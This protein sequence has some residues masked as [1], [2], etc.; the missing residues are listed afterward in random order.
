MG[1]G[2]GLR[3]PPL[4]K[5][6]SPTARCLRPH[7][8]K[9]WISPRIEAPQPFW[10]VWCL[11]T[12]TVKKTFFLIFKWDFSTCVH[13]LWICHWA[14]L[15][16][17][18]FSLLCF[19]AP[20]FQVLY[21]LRRRMRRGEERCRKCLWGIRCKWSLWILNS[22]NLFIDYFRRALTMRKKKVKRRRKKILII[23]QTPIRKMKQMKRTQY[24]L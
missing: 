22:Q 3:R 13:C 1:W 12:V 16:R 20:S 23:L 11:N 7:P 9:V 2:R 24:V 18:Q 8:I 10:T 6:G 14:P 19:F 15:K 21:T 17:V 5:V 4:L